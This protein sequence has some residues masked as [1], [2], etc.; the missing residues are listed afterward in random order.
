METESVSVFVINYGAEKQSRV[1]YRTMST[2]I[3]NYYD[4][5]KKDDSGLNNYPNEDKI[6]IK[7]PFRMLLCGPSG[8]GKT[9]LLLNFIKMKQLR[10]SHRSLHR[11]LPMKR[12]LALKLHSL[13]RCLQD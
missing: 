9:S 1:L 6:N 8:S 10:A 4:H 5:V 2:N 13:V 7:L 11:E 3:V 12:R